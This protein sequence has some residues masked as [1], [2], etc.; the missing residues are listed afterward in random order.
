MTLIA[1]IAEPTV[2]K[3]ILDHLRLRC[4]KAGRCLP[5]PNRDGRRA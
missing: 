5:R 2:A 4:V 3:R 1:F